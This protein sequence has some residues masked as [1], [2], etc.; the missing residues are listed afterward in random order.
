[1][2]EVVSRDANNMN[3]A[4]AYTF[5]EKITAHLIRVDLQTV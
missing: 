1:V 2:Y 5:I 3:S 4:Q